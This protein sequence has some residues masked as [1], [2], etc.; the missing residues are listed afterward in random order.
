[1]IIDLET[2][3]WSNP[4]D[5]GDEVTR[6]RTRGEPQ[7][8]YAL[9]A[10][11][12][13]FERAM[14]RVDVAVVLGFRSRYTGST[15]SAES[16]ASFVAKAPNCRIGFAG[17][18][19]MDEDSLESIDHAVNLGLSGITLSPSLQN[20]HPTHSRAM[21]V[22]ER[23]L[24][25][26][27]PV[28]VRQAPHLCG[29]SIMEYARPGA[30][31]EVA[32]SFTQLKLVIGHVGY[33]W[34]DETLALIGKHDNVFTDLAGISAR[35][36]KLYNTLLSAFEYGVMEKILFASDFPHATPEDAIKRIYSVNAYSR[37]TELPAIP[38][39]QLRGI[40]ERDALSCLGLERPGGASISS[41]IGH[42]FGTEPSAARPTQSVAA[43]RPALPESPREWVEPE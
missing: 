15:I 14:G 18:D 12:D 28:L 39:E 25:L 7:P 42:D 1:M 36:W 40:V 9:D 24:Q 30:L 11:P 8:W 43:S 38:R 35:P 17:I 4:A 23:C 19:P 27:L 22:Y 2:A 13:A 10:S 20:F 32:R 41:G 21:R 16:V 31:D 26:S 5:L 33:P 29:R 34:I 3:V 6:R 37:G